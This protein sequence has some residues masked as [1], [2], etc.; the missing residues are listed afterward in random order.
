MKTDL[1]KQAEQFLWNHYIDGKMGVFGC[2][3][4]FVTYG[5]QENMNESTS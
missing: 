5:L 4:V 1:T 3:E 2:F